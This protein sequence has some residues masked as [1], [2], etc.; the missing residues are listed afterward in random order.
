MILL[1]YERIRSIQS[2][3]VMSRFLDKSIIKDWTHF[4]FKAAT[5]GVTQ[6]EIDEW[7]LSD[8]EWENKYENKHET[9]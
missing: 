3:W 1:T 4:V 6:F 8:E 7:I 9:K 5:T 2:D